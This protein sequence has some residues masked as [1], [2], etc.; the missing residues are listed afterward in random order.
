MEVIVVGLMLVTV[1]GIKVASVF[2]D[3]WVSVVGLV[4]IL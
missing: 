4:M 1:V 2:V 3:I